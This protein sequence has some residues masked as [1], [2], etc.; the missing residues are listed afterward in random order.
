[1]YACQRFNTES[2]KISNVYD[3][4]VDRSAEIA[5][6]FADCERCL[7]KACDQMEKVLTKIDE[8]K[9][10]LYRSRKTFSSAC[11]AS[12]QMQLQVLQGT[13]TAFHTFGAKKG[14]QLQQLHAERCRLAASVSIDPNSLATG[15]RYV[16]LVSFCH[17]YHCL[18]KMVH[19]LGLIQA[20][21]VP[22]NTNMH[23][24]AWLKTQ[25]INLFVYVW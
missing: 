23:N 13:Y 19:G 7:N 18:L 15:G 5:E 12:L 4:I 1:M 6:Q 25:S 22:R 17:P 14:D 10:R 24:Y 16:W 21:H 8:A 2:F 11:T 9:T 20:K 3:D